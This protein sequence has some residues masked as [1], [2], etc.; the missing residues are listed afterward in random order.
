V[1]DSH[2][3]ARPDYYPTTDTEA[4]VSPYSEELL[5]TYFDVIHQSYPLLDP[6]RFNDEP[7]TN[8][9]LRAVM[10]NLA[11]PFCQDAPTFFPELS[12]FVHQAFVCLGILLRR[13][14]SIQTPHRKKTS[15]A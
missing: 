7:Q 5:R 12:A 11:A 14:T 13:L 4:I 6:S 10:Y 1:P 2:L 15:P 3:D 9:P 8:D